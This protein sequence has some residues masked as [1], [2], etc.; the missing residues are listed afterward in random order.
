MNDASDERVGG[1]IAVAFEDGAMAIRRFGR[2]GA[3]PM[4][5]AHANGFCASAYR[6][7]LTALGGRFDIFAVDLRGHGRSTLPADPA[8]YDG[9]GVHGEDLSALL[10][11]LD[12]QFAT[13]TKWTLAG[14]SLGAVSVTLAARGRGDVGAL[15]LIEPAAMPGFWRILA[16][17][18]LWSVFAERIPLVRGARRR[19]A[20]WPDRR[21]VKAAYLQKPLFAGWAEGVLDDYLEDGLR[22]VEGGA[23]LACAPDWEAASFARH[24]HD[25]WA[26]LAGAPAPVAVLAAGAGSTVSHAAMRRFV[27]LGAQIRRDERLSHLAPFEDPDACAQFLAA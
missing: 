14:H 10:S 17:S 16:G 22:D 7:M 25:F 1:R 23:A 5:F 27:R 12:E 9:M 6:R 21:S 13:G 26:A 3:P 2:I 24:R 11:R 15:R 18:P 19:R 4:L 8:A 20:M